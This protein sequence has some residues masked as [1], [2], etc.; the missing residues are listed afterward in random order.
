MPTINSVL[1]AFLDYLVYRLQLR[2]ATIR[3][4]RTDLHAAAQS[5][6][7]DVSQITP[8]QIEEVLREGTPQKATI[9]RR[10][11]SLKRFFAWCVQ[12]E[13]C[14]SNPVERCEAVRI[15][16]R[17]PR[18]IPRA[19]CACFEH[20][21]HGMHEPYRTIFWLLRETGIRA[22]EALSLRVG[23]VDLTPH[24]ETITLTTTKNGRS[25]TVYLGR[26]FTPHAVR[27]LRKLLK[28]HQQ[29][30]PHAP[31]FCSNRQSQLTYG[32]LRYQWNHLCAT[33]QFIDT[34]GHV[35]YTIHQLRH[36]RG[37][38]LIR[39]GKSFDIV[40]HVLGHRDP[41]STHLYAELH[42]DH[43]RMALEQD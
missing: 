34:E 10:M 28:H 39:E 40:Q 20:A 13:W 33:L 14:W 8:A 31:L 38:E 5:L 27:Y 11:S 36:T 37:S 21:F 9:A 4:Y 29:T 2:P 6:T 42:A 26:R 17:L 12:N 23:D 19:A 41:R 24:Q 1:P 7:E 25:R 3:A 18:P 30:P 32:A 15:E 22:G 43:I 16:Q 35:H